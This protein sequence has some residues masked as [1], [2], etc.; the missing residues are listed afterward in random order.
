MDNQLSTEIQVSLAENKTQLT[1]F[2]KK[3]DKLDDILE[4]LRELSEVQIRQEEKI[5]TIMKNNDTVNQSVQTTRDEISGVK[6]SIAELKDKN[7]E[8]ELM[9]KANETITKRVS[10]IFWSIIAIVLTSGLGGAIKFFFF[11]ATK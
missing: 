8:L 5:I 9:I 2:E 1:N 3:L 6:K 10:T 7:H 11:T 4:S